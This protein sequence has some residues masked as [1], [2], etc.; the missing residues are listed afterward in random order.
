MKFSYQDLISIYNVSEKTLEAGCLRYRQGKSHSWKNKKDPKDRR[1]VLIELDSIPEATRLKYNIP[2]SAEY[3]A[4]QTAER[5][6]E[7]LRLHEEWEKTQAELEKERLFRIEEAKDKDLKALHSAYQGNEYK[8]YY[9]D[10]QKLLDYRTESK[11]IAEKLARENAFWLKVVNLCNGY[12]YTKRCFELYSLLRE[13]LG[14]TVNLKGYETFKKR[15]AE[16]RKQKEAFGTI[17]GTFSG[18]YRANP[19]KKKTGEVHHMLAYSFLSHEKKYSTRVVTDLMNHH[20]QE[21]NELTISESWVKKLLTNNEFRT[22]V[23][24]NRNGNKW[25]SD[26]IFASAVRENTPYPADCWMIDGT[27]IRFYCWNK[28]RTKT[29][30]LNLF[31]IIDVCTRKIVGFDISYSESKYNIMNALQNAVR[32]EGHLPA[33]IVS[34]NFTAV[35]SQE[36][37]ALKEQMEKIGTTWRHAQVGNPQDKSYIERFFGAFQSVE[38]ALYDDYIGEGITSKR[39]NRPNAEYLAEV[40]K[41]K[42]LPTYT[43]MISRIIKMV[44]KY[45]ERVKANFKQSPMQL[46]KALPK[47]NASELNEVQTA[48]LFWKR[49]KV[50]VRR[51]TVKFKI[52]SVMQ[53]YEVHDHDL[54]MKLQGKEVYV[55]YDEKDLDEIMLFDFKN[56]QAICKCKKALS[57]NTARVNRTE[58]DDL[59]TMKIVAKK[60]SYKKHLKDKGDAIIDAGL[61]AIG[62][63]SLDLIH[64]LSLDKNQIN[65]EESKA[66]VE[67]YLQIFKIAPDQ[68]EKPHKKP[69]KTIYHSGVSSEYSNMIEKGAKRKSPLKNHHQAE[70]TKIST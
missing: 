69:L 12:G 68:E 25:S 31:A 2:T 23:E 11:K 43:E 41:K 40:A 58:E 27:P 59:N 45:N 1:K 62:T 50:T 3:I 55:R 56:E 19:V 64:P 39:N 8:K 35:K 47:P 29:V 46:Y 37:I 57:I 32:L 16:F 53:H 6:A 10:Y 15:V 21:L 44:T 4:R 65:E 30:R 49:T 38:C 5:D 14:L 13:K 67:Q 66:F 54:K 34:D 52:N 9:L 42:G 26:N 48:L 28:S 36:I 17:T 51:G 63:D 33:E 7:N 18:Y 24:A 22:L 20:L 70:L 61:K 60:K